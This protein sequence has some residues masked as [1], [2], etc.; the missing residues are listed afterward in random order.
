[1]APSAPTNLTGQAIS[2]TEIELNW[3]NTST[4][5]VQRIEL[6]RKVG[7]GQWEILNAQIQPSIET[8]TLVALQDGVDYSFRMRARNIFGY[9]AYTDE[10]TVSTP[11]DPRLKVV[12]QQGLDE[13]TGTVDLELRDAS[14]DSVFDGAGSMTVDMSDGGVV[15]GMMRFKNV[16][17]N[18]PAEAEIA[19]AE[20]Q[21]L[22]SSNSDG[23]QSLYRMLTDWPDACTWN[24]LGGDGVSPDGVEATADAE[25]SVT[26]PVSGDFTYFDVTTSVIAWMSGAPNYGWGIIN[27][28]TDGWDLTTSENGTLEYRPKLTV[29]YTLPCTLTGDLN[30]DDIVNAL[31]YQIFRS[32]YGQTGPNVADLNGDEYVNGA[33][34]QMLRSNYGTSC[35]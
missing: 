18:L 32:N 5:P 29:Y 15:H 10:I 23:T 19:S 12:F 21:V 26:G 3:E 13:Y 33:D 14:P 16:V 6:E 24:T 22:T 8:Y 9:S 34:Y 31:D 27:S 35:P 17:D 1:V 4:E 30:G 11:A 7:D 20:L 28:S 25:A 2:Y